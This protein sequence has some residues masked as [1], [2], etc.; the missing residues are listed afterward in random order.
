MENEKKEKEKTIKP[1][2]LKTSMPTPKTDSK[3]EKRMD[4]EQMK[5]I[6]KMVV[7][8]PPEEF[9]WIMKRQ[10]LYWFILLL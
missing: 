3:K 4:Y 2:M 8:R 5:L 6:L 9:P 1:I 7:D 10:L